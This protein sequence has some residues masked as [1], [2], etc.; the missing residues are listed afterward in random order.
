MESE[1]QMIVKI[2]V[3]WPNAKSRETE[4]DIGRTR[5]GHDRFRSKIHIQS[6]KIEEP[7]F[8]DL[9]PKFEIDHLSLKIQDRSFKHESHLQFK[10]KTSLLTR[11]AQMVYAIYKKMNILSMD[12]DRVKS[13]QYILC[14]SNYL[15]LTFNNI[16]RII[17][18]KLNTV[19]IT[20]NRF[21]HQNLELYVT[22]ET[23]HL[24]FSDL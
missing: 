7:K 22:M 2:F 10:L 3:A 19:L 8:D 12:R 4:W 21:Y 15:K 14:K 6:F 17:L 1:T 5:N 9:K 16:K 11:Q 24:F 18:Q 13:N 23:P 20:N